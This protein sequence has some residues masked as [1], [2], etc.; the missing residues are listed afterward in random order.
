MPELKGDVNRY[1]CTIC[2]STIWTI[3]AAHGTTPAMMGCRKERCKGMMASAFY[4]D[5]PG[6]EDAIE[7]EWY[8]P[9]RD[10]RR[11]LSRA[12]KEHVSLGGLLIRKRVP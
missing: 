3:L 1:T 12:M 9:A 4:A 5:Q 2:G 11:R 6:P 10:E 7:Y 8:R